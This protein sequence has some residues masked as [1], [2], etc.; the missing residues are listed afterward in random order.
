MAFDRRRW[1][2]EV[3]AWW[4]EHGPGLKAAPIKSAY[5]LLA[6]SAW[7]PFLAAYTPDPGAAMIALVGITAGIGGNLVANVVQNGYD[8]ARGGEQ[9]ADQ[10]REDAQI[11][12]ELDAILQATGALEAAQEALGERWDEFAR[13]LSQEIAAL[14][15]RSGLTVTLG[16]GTVVGGSVIAGGL[17]MTGSTF[18][19][20]DYTLVQA[21]TALVSAAPA[22]QKEEAQERALRA[23]LERLTR[24]CNVLHLRGMDPRAADVTRQ[25][26]MSLAA[27]YTTMNTNRRM[28]LSA[29]ERGAV[30]ESGP[31]PEEIAREGSRERPQRPMSALEVASNLIEYHAF[32]GDGG[33]RTSKG[34]R[35]S[36]AGPR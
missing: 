17:T 14:P 25:E 3:R 12:T 15:G 19:G 7:L 11:H 20:R 1:Q 30:A 22:D 8:R 27:V 10:A 35:E 13:Q 2:S 5:A 34:R 16:D 32:G 9:A 36:E 29:E 18:V 28:D 23:Y 33:G 6:T 21:E 24:E 4:T 26:T 31:Q